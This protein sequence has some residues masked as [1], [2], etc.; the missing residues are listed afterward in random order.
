MNFRT[1]LSRLNDFPTDQSEKF[2]I[3]PG[4]LIDTLCIVCTMFGVC[5]SLGLGVIQLNAGLQSVNSSIP[6]NINTQLIIIWSVTAMATFSVVSGIKVGIRRLS[7]ICFGIGKVS[8]FFVHAQKS[9]HALGA[10]E[11]IHRL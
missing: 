3:V 6:D 8:S 10:G 2:Y 7:E 5:T 1:K 11:L 4:D 9:N